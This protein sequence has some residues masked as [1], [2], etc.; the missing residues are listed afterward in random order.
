MLLIILPLAKKGK[1]VKQKVIEQVVDLA[2]QIE[3]ENTQV[4]VITGILVSSD[5]FIDRDYAK[6]V[7]R[8]L[9]MTKVFQSLEEEKL[10]AVNIAK[11]NERHDTN[12]EI[13]KS[14]LRDGIDT[15]VIMR[16]TGFSKEQIEEIRNNM[17]TTKQGIRTGC[18]LPRGIWQSFCILSFWKVYWGWLCVCP[19]LDIVFVVYDWYPSK[20]EKL[21]YQTAFHVKNGA[22]KVVGA[23][24]AEKLYKEY[25]EKYPYDMEEVE[26][27]LRDLYEN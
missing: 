23:S 13:A 15:V 11:R 21:L 5:K 4:F 3:D 6:S 8:Y 18:H 2:K 9:S 1:E 19:D 20:N 27:W 7:R 16:A 22:V 24:E 26:R 14:L 10:E 12:V 25:H 17:L